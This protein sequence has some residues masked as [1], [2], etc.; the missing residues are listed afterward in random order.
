MKPSPGKWGRIGLV[1]NVCFLFGASLAFPAQQV[2]IS[3]NDY[4]GYTG[5]VDYLKKVATAYPNIAELTEI[6]KSNKGRSIYVLVISNLKTGTTIDKLVPLHNM[7]NEP[8]TQNVI[9]M[10]PYQ[11]KPGI[12][13]DGGM[14]GNEF[15]GTEV[16]LYIVDKLV[17]GYGTDPDITRQ[18]DEDVFYICPAV[19]PDGVFSSVEAGSLQLQNSPEPEETGAVQAAVNAP[20]DINGDGIIS[21]FRYKDPRGPY[22]VYDADPRVMLPLAQGENTTKERYSVVWE[23]QARTNVESRSGN[24]EGPGGIDI[25][26]NFPEGWWRDD[27]LQGGS[28]HYPSS[29]PEAHAILEFFTNHTNILLVQSLHTS[30]G[31]TNRPYAHWPDSRIDPK[32][33]AIFDMVMGRKYLELI[34]EEMPEAWRTDNRSAGAGQPPQ[35]R[36]AARSASADRGGR[37]PQ[38]W[39]HAYNEDQGSPYGYG[40]FIDWAYGQFGAY[41]ISTELW[42]W[43]RDS[44]NLP[45]YA[46]END[47]GLWE[48]AYIKYQETA[49]GG[50]AFLPWKSFNHPGI[51]DG[52]IGGWVTKYSP[53]NAI[54]GPSLAAVCETQ[55]K[56]ESY[57]ASLL[58]RLEISDAKAAVLYTTDSATDAKAEQQGDVF[59]IKKGKPTGKYKVVQVTATVKNLGALPTQ[60]ARGAQLAGNREDV[61][62]LLGERDKIHFL[63]GSQWARLGVLDAATPIPGY[64]PPAPPQAAGAGRG[65]GG[66]PTTPGAPARG[67]RGQIPADQQVRGAGNSREVTWLVAVEGETPLKLV[68][69][70]QRGGT[71]VKELPLK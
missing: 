19:N 53:G 64:I 69:T 3:F 21:Q 30:G 51:G 26:F 28:G 52:E 47:R 35:G 56:Y 60:I 38:G 58:P 55:W 39:R 8:N 24:A 42:N 14:H 65:R 62:W 54:P 2:P 57:R 44:K 25:N 13:I 61:I 49:L 32:D 29:S 71:R 16:C 63:E 7:R 48:S 36:G 22:V 18:I 6:G 70:S 20:R 17:S 9:P 37:G 33:L 10:K 66:S 67:M 11:G 4:H 5:T 46:G 59:T 43:Q 41:A 27:G 23:G 40:L 34:G 15:T 12:W 68:L 45:G 50:K 31:F 1:F